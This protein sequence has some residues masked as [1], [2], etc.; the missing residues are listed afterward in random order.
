MD[1]ARRLEALGPYTLGQRLG[2]GGMA[3]V[4]EAESP[5]YGKVAVK[6]I[7]P[8]LA[9]DREFSDMFWDEAR[10]TS[11]LDHRNV[12]KVLD[13]GR[14]DGQLFMA[15]EYVDGP[16]AAKMLRRAANKRRPLD[17]G[18]VVSMICQLLDALAFVHEARDEKG[19]ALQIV[20]R[21]V[22][23]GNLLINSRGEVKLG[24]FGI[25]RSDLVM[26]R[27]QPGELKG[28]IGYMSPEQAVGGPLDTRSDLFSVG[29]ILAEFL[30]LRPLL[31]G[32]NEMQT[33]SRTVQADLTTWH[34]FDKNVPMP[35]RAIVERALRRDANER[36]DS[37]RSMR[38]ALLDVARN[39][40]WNVEPLVVGHTLTDLGFVERP[41]VGRNVSG[42]R[43]ITR[44]KGA[45]A[46]IDERSTQRTGTS[47]LG[48][49]QPVGGQPRY[50]GKPVWRVDF[51]RLSLP[52]QLMLAIRRAHDGAV[53]LSSE[54]H[55]VTLELRHGCIVAAHDSAG[56]AP[57]GRLLLEAGV[58]QKQDLVSA[59]GESRR[60]SLRLGEYLV[61]Q[62]RVRESTLR[63]A[64]F[65]QTMVRVKPWFGVGSGVL[66]VFLTEGCELDDDQEKAPESVAQLI[67]ILRQVMDSESL[68]A[69]LGPILDSV[70]LPAPM[71]L[72]P[73]ELGL[74]A[75]ETRVL[76]T[77]LQ[78]GMFEGRSPRYVIDSLT[79]ERIARYREAC[80]ALFVGLAAGLIQAPGFGR[81]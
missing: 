48:V 12:I 21:D 40:G 24:D 44:A 39:A 70:L 18:V 35:L 16:S 42:E 2:L 63:R 80:F 6:R 79:H 26:R 13:Y 51:D 75:P 77:A 73:A 20:H 55:S 56:R 81:H 8:T 31:L 45:A 61:M 62:R 29:V 49:M 17:P 43:P 11:R 30:I 33:L 3:E 66:S 27:T 19:R 52:T 58:V 7:L 69:Q 72:D 46:G 32:K 38:Q 1:S 59:I 36:F 10:V 9:D 37:A 64:L 65:E 78:G 23:P 34:R 74:T 50:A 71:P 57:L 76:N 68:L 41:E 60:A 28:K 22:S 47:G 14:I 5:E 54:G 15:L 53:E 4:F 67:S 25:V